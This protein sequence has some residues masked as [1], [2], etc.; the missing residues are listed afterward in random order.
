MST[1]L[2]IRVRPSCS[3]N[4]H[5]VLVFRFFYDFLLPDGAAFSEAD[6]KRVRKTMSRII[7]SNLP[8][9]M[10]TVTRDEAR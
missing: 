2:D 9:T 4:R 1:I 3:H 10:E 8:I 5:R 6:L 7:K